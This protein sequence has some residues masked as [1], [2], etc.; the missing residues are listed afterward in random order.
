MQLFR[1]FRLVKKI[2][3]SFVKSGPFGGYG[4]TRPRSWRRLRRRR[5]SWRPTC[6]RRRGGWRC[7]LCPWEW[8]CNSARSDRATPTEISAFFSVGFQGQIRMTATIVCYICAF[9]SSPPEILHYTSGISGNP[10]QNGLFVKIVRARQLSINRASFGRGRGS[11][12]YHQFQQMALYLTRAR[13]KPI[14]TATS[15]FCATS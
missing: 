1:F 5:R 4:R 15:S 9:A 7:V 2:A 6:G 12:H 11:S 14:G 3:I 13:A 10:V 8:A